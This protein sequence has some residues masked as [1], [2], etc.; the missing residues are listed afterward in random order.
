MRR[1]VCKRA[2]KER[3]CHV[4]ER[5][6]IEKS[7]NEHWGHRGGYSAE[8]ES[9]LTEYA[10]SMGDRSTHAAL[11]AA[12]ERGANGGNSGTKGC[13]ILRREPFENWRGS[14]RSLHGAMDKAK[15]C[16]MA[17]RMLTTYERWQL[18]ARYMC[19]IANLPIGMNEQLGELSAVAIVV[20]DRLGLSHRLAAD[21]TKKRFRQWTDV[22]AMALQDTHDQ[23]YLARA[24]VDREL[25]AAGE[26][27]EGTVVA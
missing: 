23:Y 26:V 18:C 16:E 22:A 17:L 27:T 21:A 13:G 14:L 19:R 1:L 4:M 2:M 25:A 12:I 9:W 24:E 5:T 20:A 3:R 8:V 11:V 6:S 10:A 7:T 15:R